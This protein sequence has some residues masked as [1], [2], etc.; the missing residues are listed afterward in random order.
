M[1]ALSD[2]RVELAER[3][4]VAAIGAT[5]SVT[6]TSVAIRFFAFLEERDVTYCVV[7]D[8][9]RLPEDIASDIDIVV[10]PES[11]ADLPAHLDEFCAEQH[12]HLVQCLR[13][14]VAAFY[15]VVAW[16]GQAGRFEFLHLDICGDYCRDA[17]V[18]LRAERL[19]AGRRTAQA[20]DGTSKGFSVPVPAAAFIYYLLKRIDKESLDDRHGEF[21]S[22]RWWCD[23]RG[24]LDELCRYWSATEVAVIANAAARGQWGEVQAML[25][26]LRRSL[27]RRA[28]SLTRGAEV[29]R[30]VD[31][32]LHPTGFFVAV[33][34]VDGSG[35]TTVIER[36][37]VD[38][39]PAFRRTLTLHF[40]PR[41]GER[42]NTNG[43]VT[44][45]H[46]ASPRAL[47]ASA[48][49]AVYY[50]YDFVIGY[51]WRLRPRLVRSTLLLFDRYAADFEADPRRFRY[52]GPQWLARLVRRLAPEPDL[53]LLL[54]APADALVAHVV[55]ATQPLDAV[56][57][58][59]ESIVVNCLVARLRRRH[60]LVPRPRST[61][62]ATRP[63]R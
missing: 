60:G 5:P 33:L 18:F 30:R 11:L 26:P 45:P 41:F 13:H 63:A 61:L 52:G 50:L 36:L 10:H 44:N 23:P 12:L 57:A 55:D 53:V 24:A 59:A 62:P 46:G 2:S 48:A 16:R 8:D 31:R 37:A 35:K 4:T 49:K 7:G 51:H 40:R 47:A 14:E 21:L 25:G 38:L 17:R 15:F 43:P 42:A 56:V 39:A 1:R 20:P 58:A 6:R 3:R 32:V 22:A 27:H 9:R 19:L 54:D 34:G 28:A 29:A